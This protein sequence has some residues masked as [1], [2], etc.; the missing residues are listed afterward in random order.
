MDYFCSSKRKDWDESENSPTTKC[1]ETVKTITK[2]T[3][4]PKWIIES[5]RGK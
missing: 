1:L 3:F 5:K 2:T 4:F